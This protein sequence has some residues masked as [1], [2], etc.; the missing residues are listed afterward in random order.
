M[1][2]T[3]NYDKSTGDITV[4]SDVKGISV[5]V[6]SNAIQDNSSTLFFEVAIDTSVYEATE[7]TIETL[8]TPED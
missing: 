1:I 4:G 6:N 3:V 8:E 2:L 7:A 5:E